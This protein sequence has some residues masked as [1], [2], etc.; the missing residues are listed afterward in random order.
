MMSPLIREVRCRVCC[1][2]V[3]S[4]A[5]ATELVA[6]LHQR[7]KALMVAQVG[8]STGHEPANNTMNPTA[9]GRRPPASRLRSPAA[10]YGER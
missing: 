5:S 1:F 10:G 6:S 8:G 7:P 2:S 9:G 4:A 3:E